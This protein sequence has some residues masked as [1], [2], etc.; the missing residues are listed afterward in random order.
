M[1]RCL[2]GILWFV[3]VCSVFESSIG[4]FFFAVLEVGVRCFAWLS[5]LFWVMFSGFEQHVFFLCGMSSVRFPRHLKTR[6][7]CTTS[8]ITHSRDMYCS[9]QNKFE[10]FR[11]FLELISRFEF[12]FRRCGF[13]FE[14]FEF[15]VCSGFNHTKCGCTCACAVASLHPQ[16]S[17]SNVV[18]SL[19]IHDNTLSIYIYIYIFVICEHICICIVSCVCVCVCVFFVLSG[20]ERW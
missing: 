14:R 10:R 20:L 4:G 11:W 19:M 16:N 6:T 18:V 15:L 7:T 9:R 12:E 3:V 5:D 8:V 2:R 13:F 1:L 17:S